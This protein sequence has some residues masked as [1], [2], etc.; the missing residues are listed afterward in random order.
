MCSIRSLDLSTLNFGTYLFLVLAFSGLLVYAIIFMNQSPGTPINAAD[1]LKMVEYTI[2]P[3]QSKGL[4]NN[5]MAVRPSASSILF[6]TLVSFVLR[7][8]AILCLNFLIIDFSNLHPEIGLLGYF[9]FLLVALL[10]VCKINFEGLFEKRAVSIFGP[11]TLC[12]SL[13]S[14]SQLNHLFAKALE[15]I[16]GRWSNIH[17]PNHIDKNALSKNISILYEFTH[18]MTSHL[19]G[20]YFFVH[21]APITH[22]DEKFLLMVAY[23]SYIDTIFEEFLHGPVYWHVFCYF[24]PQSSF[25]AA[26]K[27][28]FDNVISAT[29]TSKYQKQ[30]ALKT[31]VADARILG[32]LHKNVELLIPYYAHGYYHAICIH[33]DLNL[34]HARSME[35]LRLASNTKST[36]PQIEACFGI[37]NL[38]KPLQD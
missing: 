29:N 30:S 4:G 20:T 38:C 15:E 33:D 1:Q 37:A 18:A 26:C 24:D 35:I 8:C 22:E 36:K 12:V 2:Q 16:F 11:S 21:R 3:L 23:N 13:Y 28:N 27:A 6:T 17:I 7:L 10:I 19:E 34:V 25:V 9:T 32:F 31:P 5:S 14:C